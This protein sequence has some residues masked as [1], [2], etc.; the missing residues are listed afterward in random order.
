MKLIVGLGNPGLKYKNTWHNAGFMAVDLL[1]KNGFSKF[2][3]DKKF[4]AEIAEGNIANE[5]VILAKP[6]TFMNNSGQ[7]VQAIANFYKINPE[8]IWVVHDEIDIPISKLRISFDASA[9]GNN[10]IKSIINSLATQ[11]FVRFRLGIRP[12]DENKTPTEKYVLQKI[13]KQSKVKLQEV[14]NQAT[15]AIQSAISDGLT[16]AMNQYN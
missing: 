14:L 8:D 3:K 7:A 11:K 2:K 13:D 12:Q 15:Q 16:S 6:L 4:N 1:A 9:A 10:G 5:K